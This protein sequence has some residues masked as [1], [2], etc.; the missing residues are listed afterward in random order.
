MWRLIKNV[1]GWWLMVEVGLSVAGALEFCKFLSDDCYVECVYM[2]LF[3]V[4]MCNI[5]FIL[6]Y[7]YF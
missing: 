7:L 2:L 3:F 4:L 6:W 5:S 1:R